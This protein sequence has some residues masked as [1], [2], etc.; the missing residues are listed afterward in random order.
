MAEG[1]AKRMWA[2]PGAELTAPASLLM[3][4]GSDELL[5]L[6]CPSFLI[7]H[8][9]GL[10]LFDTGCNAKVID[11]AVGYWGEAG[12]HCRSSGASLRRSTSRSRVSATKPRT[13]STSSFPTRIWI[14]RAV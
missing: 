1:K 3:H 2:L 13:S 9:K 6:P 14:T 10:V 11:D 7:E 4:G 12:R 8:A 5:Q